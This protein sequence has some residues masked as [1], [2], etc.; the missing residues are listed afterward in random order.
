MHQGRDVVYEGIINPISPFLRVCKM[1]KI[2]I[3]IK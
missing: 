3:G 2:G 1:D